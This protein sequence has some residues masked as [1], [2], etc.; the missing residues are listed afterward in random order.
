MRQGDSLKFY[1]GYFQNQLTMV[2]NCDEDISALTF[3][4]GLQVS[5]PLYKHL[6]KHDVTRISEVLFRA[7][8]YI[9]L[10]EDMKK[11][12]QPLSQMQQ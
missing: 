8:P 11:F 6:I 10:E 2:L 1:L 9:Q 3:I 12:C 4:S 7:Q 5:H